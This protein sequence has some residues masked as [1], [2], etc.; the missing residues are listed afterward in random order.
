MGEMSARV[1]RWPAATRPSATALP[2]IIETSRS[3]DG[4][5]IS[6]VTSSVSLGLW[7][8][9]L[10]ALSQHAGVHGHQTSIS[11]SR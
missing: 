9:H 11:S 8:L 10:E 3:D 6:T 7:M 2:L 5:P 1:T 4:P